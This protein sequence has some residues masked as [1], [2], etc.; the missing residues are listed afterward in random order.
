MTF[1]YNSEVRHPYE[2]E[3]PCLSKIQRRELVECAHQTALRYCSPIYLVGSALTS[4]YPNDIDLFIAVPGATYLRLMT[5]YNR[6]NE[7]EDHMLNI[8][9]MSIQQ[10]R[11]YQKQKRY[12]ES[13]IKGWD[14]DIKFQNVESFMKHDGLRM[15]LDFL[16]EGVW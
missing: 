10:A 1:P 3:I 6:A 11:L 9:R 4:E 15:R 2:I 14:F 16:Y 7:S 13:K 12:F 5:N 8:Q